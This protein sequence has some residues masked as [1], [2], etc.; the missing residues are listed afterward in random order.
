M[1]TAFVGHMFTPRRPISYHARNVAGAWG[2]SPS[3]GRGRGIL[4]RNERVAVR[5]ATLAACMAFSDQ[6][7]SEEC[8]MAETL[9]EYSSVCGSSIGHDTERARRERRFLGIRGPSC[10]NSRTRV[11]EPEE[12]GPEGRGHHASALLKACGAGS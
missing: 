11:V 7:S 3:P 8:S 6:R 4:S 10:R 12:L 9:R 2:A 1:H 5:Q